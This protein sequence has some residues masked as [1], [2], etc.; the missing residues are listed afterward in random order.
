[1]ISLLLQLLWFFFCGGALMFLLLFVEARESSGNLSGLVTCGELTVGVL[2]AIVI[3]IATPGRPWW[4]FVTAFVWLG[5]VWVLEA[6]H[7]M[8]QAHRTEKKFK[9]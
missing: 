2:G 5:S 9:R 1:M 6:V 8:L 4:L 3:A 7:S